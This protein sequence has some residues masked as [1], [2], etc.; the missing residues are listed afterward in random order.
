LNFESFCLSG[1]L[2]FNS[3]KVS[4]H[5]C[6]QFGHSNTSGLNFVHSGCVNG[7][8]SCDRES[9]RGL[10]LGSNYWGCSCFFLDWG[11]CLSGSLWCSLFRSWLSGGWGCCFCRCSICLNS[12][13]ISWGRRLL[14][15]SLDIGRVVSGITHI[16]ERFFK[17]TSKAT[18]LLELDQFCLTYRT[19]LGGLSE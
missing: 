6:L 10:G 3:L 5:F 15:R 12:R 9:S 11:G 8:C 19:G 1:S 13:I 16:L 17:K 7:S 4:I 14:G 18:R 2:I